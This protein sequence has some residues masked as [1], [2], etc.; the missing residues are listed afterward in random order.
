[1]GII[2]FRLN[3]GMTIYIDSGLLCKVEGERQYN[4]YHMRV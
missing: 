3:F 4:T 2:L 1:L